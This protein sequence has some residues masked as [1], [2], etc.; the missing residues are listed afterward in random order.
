[1]IKDVAAYNASI[2]PTWV[3]TNS[4]IWT[5]VEVQQQLMEEVGE[6]NVWPVTF[7]VLLKMYIRPQS[8]DIGGVN[9]DTPEMYL[10]QDQYF[11]RVGK[12][13][14]WGPDAFADPRRFPA[15]PP[16]NIG[17]WILFRRYENSLIG[18][19]GTPLCFIL[20]DKFIARVKDPS[21]VD[22]SHQIGK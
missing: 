13:L 14:G 17:D 11:N 1:M 22:T 9:Y 12:V 4:K 6:D 7:H 15:G 20:D 21:R 19:N 3:N 18:V 8:R 16:C 10:D 2:Q 5:P